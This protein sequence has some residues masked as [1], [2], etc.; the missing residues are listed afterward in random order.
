[1][2]EQE[3]KCAVIERK[4][5]G[6]KNSG[7][8]HLRTEDVRC[9]GVIVENEPNQIAGIAH[10]ARHRPYLTCRA[11]P[12]ASGNSWLGPGGSSADVTAA[13]HARTARWFGSKE[14]ATDKANI[15]PDPDD[16]GLYLQGGSF[17]NTVVSDVGVEAHRA[18]DAVTTAAKEVAS[19]A[20]KFQKTDMAKE[21]ERGAVDIGHVGAEV[22]ADVAAEAAATAA[23]NP[24]LGIPAAIAIH[25]GLDEASDAAKSA[26]DGS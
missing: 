22:G 15:D 1:M 5:H 3:N 24:E 12:L 6:T 7:G 13:R 14:S 18:S 11:G 20:S 19:A 10:R 2:F 23:G 21:I 17:W 8:P 16:V 26:I 25:A 4:H 9:Q